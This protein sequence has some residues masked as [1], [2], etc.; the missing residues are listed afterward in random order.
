MSDKNQDYAELTAQYRVW[1]NFD[2]SDVDY[3]GFCHYRRYFS[4]EIKPTLKDI[5]VPAR[6]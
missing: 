4:W 2:L 3:V 5:F 6:E 1:K